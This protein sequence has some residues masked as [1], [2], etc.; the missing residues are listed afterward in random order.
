MKRIASICTALLLL[1]VFAVV[2]LPAITAAQDASAEPAAGPAGT[3]FTFRLSGFNGNERLGIWLNAPNG[4]ILAI[5]GNH[6]FANGGQYTFTWTSRAGVALGT[7]QL[8]AEGTES[9]RQQVVS[10]DVTEAASNPPVGATGVN[11]QIGT[12]GDTLTFYAAG[13]FHGER[14]GFWLNTM[15]GIVPLDDMKHYAN[16]RGE[17]STTW[18]VPAGVAPGAWQLVAQGTSSGVQQV[19][20]FEIR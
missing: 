7:W 5:G 11:P 20:P 6:A 16:D 12:A 17:F 9:D 8:V 3:T 1:L 15:S 13:F 18:Q 2:S 14:I 19:I 4:T 10:F